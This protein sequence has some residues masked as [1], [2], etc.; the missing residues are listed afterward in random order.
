MSIGWWHRFSAPTAQDPYPAA[1]VLDYREHVQPCPGQ[2]DRFEEVAGKQ[3]L[4]LGAQE[5]GPRGGAALG[6]RVDPGLVQDLPDGGGGDLYPEHQQLAVYPAVPPP[7][8]LADQA[9]HQGADRAHGPRS[10][11][12]LGPGRPGMS[13]RDHIAVP[14]EHGIRAHHQVQS[15]ENLPWEPVQQRC[16]QSPVG[17]GEPDPVGAKLPL[18]D[19]ELVAQHEN[20]RIFVTVAHRQ[21]SQQR[22]HVRHA[23]VGQSQQPGPSPCHSVS[24]SH[25]R[26]H[27]QRSPSLV[28]RLRPVVSFATSGT[29][30]S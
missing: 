24:P 16:Q 7:G 2:G 10:S 30:C 13:A 1:G 15:P 22:E 25:G 21:Q 11:R 4:S 26:Y 8:I 3:G 20:F 17:R 23:E 18:E 14:A 28:Q 29:T 6:C 19:R 27:V 5:I 9:Q 12:V